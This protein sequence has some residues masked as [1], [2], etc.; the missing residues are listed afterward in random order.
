VV[1][2]YARFIRLE[3]FFW[4]IQIDLS[5]GSQGNNE[6]HGRYDRR[7]SLSHFNMAHDIIACCQV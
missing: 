1:A 2:I 5:K 3:M 6:N 7:P 4:K